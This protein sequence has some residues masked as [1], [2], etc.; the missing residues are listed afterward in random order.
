[1]LFY[2]SL[3]HLS[4]T[5]AALLKMMDLCFL[6]LR[7]WRSF[8]PVCSGTCLGEAPRT[9][10]IVSW[11]RLGDTSTKLSDHAVAFGHWS[12][13][14]SGG[15]KACMWPRTL[16]DHRDPDT[17]PIVVKLSALID[18]TTSCINFVDINFQ[19]MINHRFR[20][21]GTSFTTAQ[22][23]QGS[24]T[25]LPSTHVF[26]RPSFDGTTFSPVTD[27][28]HARLHILTQS[29]FGTHQAPVKRDR[30]APLCS[31]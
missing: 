14:Q 8:H 10:D 30:P 7:R 27:K 25:L 24:F 2:S 22:L 16:S 4:A 5:A 13:P 12:C 18:A 31:V 9:L 21:P 3:P 1:M 20:N 19:P 17:R 11:T 15:C 28:M 23:F 29:C 6:L 26:Q